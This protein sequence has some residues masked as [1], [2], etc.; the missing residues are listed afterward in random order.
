M[1]GEETLQATHKNY[2]STYLGD[3]KNILDLKSS[4]GSVKTRR[5][6][7]T[8]TPAPFQSFAS[9][10]H[11]LYVVL[12]HLD[13]QMQTLEKQPPLKLDYMAYS[14]SKVFLKAFY[15]FF[16][17]LL[18]DIAAIIEYFYKH[19]EPK[20]AIPE[21]YNEL[22]KKAMN[23]SLPPDLTRLLTPTNSWFSTM[24]GR[25]DDLVHKYESLLISIE[26]GTHGQNRLGHFGIKQRSPMPYGDIREYIGALLNC[27][28]TL[29][30]SLLDHLDTKFLDWYRIVQGQSGRHMT[31]LVGRAALPLWWAY[32]YGGYRHEHLQIMNPDPMDPS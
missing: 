23:G 30:D 7:L 22:L 16:R 27:Y 13:A 10:T 25:R 6:G 26:Q 17:I 9:S 21:R 32:H 1:D 15:I 12:A 18:D 8:T 14:E 28:Q 4:L 11:D 19:N 31:I 3:W 24:K 29:I 20:V 2:L 5:G